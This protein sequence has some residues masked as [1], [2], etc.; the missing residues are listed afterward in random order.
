MLDL[1]AIYNKTEAGVA[2]VQARALGLRAELRRLLILVDGQTPVS[3]LAAFVRGAEI[4]SHIFELETQGLITSPNSN[5]Y[6]KTEAGVAEVEKRI[7]GLRPALRRL[8]ILMDGRTPLARLASFIPGLEINALVAELEALGLI[9]A[10]NTGGSSASSAN[11][12][13]VA[14]ASRA[15][16]P[17]LSVASALPEALETPAALTDRPPVTQARLL[18]VRTAAMRELERIL[19]LVEHELLDKLKQPGDSLQLRAVISEIH[20][21]LDEQFGVAIG[22]RFLD[23]VRSTTESS[24]NEAS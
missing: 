7:L 14:T 8:L 5:A 18:A 3:R 19:G 23:A 16:L 22:Q 13:S 2:E 11:V 12:A 15:T 1:S 17:G 10:P 20:Q 24:R 4:V 21:T 6:R 9:V